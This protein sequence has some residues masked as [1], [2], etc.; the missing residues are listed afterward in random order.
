[1]SFE[2]SV[3][4]SERITGHR[5]RG[6]NGFL[7]RVAERQ[8]LTDKQALYSCLSLTDDQ[9]SSHSENENVNPSAGSS[10]CHRS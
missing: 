1:M 3:S 2:W 5:G 9:S 6:V 7:F 8:T 4:L 10:E